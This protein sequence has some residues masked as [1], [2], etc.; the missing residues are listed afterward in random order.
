MEIAILLGHSVTKFRD[1]CSDGYGNCEL[2]VT[3]FRSLSP[4]KQQ[5]AEVEK[6]IVQKIAKASSLRLALVTLMPAPAM[7]DARAV[8]L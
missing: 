8:A 2:A 4:I 3:K 1:V 5:N 7:I 6:P